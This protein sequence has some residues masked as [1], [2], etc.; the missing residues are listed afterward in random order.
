MESAPSASSVLLFP[1]S[2][3]KLRGGAYATL[4]QTWNPALEDVWA[5]LQQPEVEN[6]RQFPFLF[7]T[8]NPSII[9]SVLHELILVQR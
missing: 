6:C 8:T 1:C 4:Q 9:T 2:P 5:N 3:G 7:N